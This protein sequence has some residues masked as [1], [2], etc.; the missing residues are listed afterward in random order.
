MAEISDNHS[1]NKSA[2]NIL[3]KKYAHT[4]KDISIINHPSNINNR[5]YLFFNSV[6]LLKNIRNKKNLRRFIFP[7]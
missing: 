2:F 6:H 7:Q 3:V 4:R 1:T 5:I